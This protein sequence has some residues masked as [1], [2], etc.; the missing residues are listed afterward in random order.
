MNLDVMKNAKRN[1]IAGIANKLALILCPF[2]TRTI[3]QYTLGAEYLGLDSLFS[4]V[5]SI[6]SLSELGFGTA[7]V[8]HMYRPVAENDTETVCA[9]LNFYKKVYRCIGRSE[10]HTSELQSPA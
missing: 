9:L 8:Y 3:I 1:I 5:I 10:E 6:L 4:S 2:V 7:V